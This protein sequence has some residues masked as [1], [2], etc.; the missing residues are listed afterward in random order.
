MTM[1]HLQQNTA[2]QVGFYQSFL[3]YKELLT[4][5]VMLKCPAGVSVSV[6][7]AGLSAGMVV[8]IVIIV[9]MVFLGLLV[10]LCLLKRRGWYSSDIAERNGSGLEATVQ[11]TKLNFCVLFSQDW[12]VSKQERGLMW[13]IQHHPKVGCLSY[14]SFFCKELQK[15]YSI[16]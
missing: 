8:V 16:L 1:R 13:K 5:L 6:Y 3:I 4:P 10:A 12:H 11:Y 2:N 15:R 9:L 14:L 7:D